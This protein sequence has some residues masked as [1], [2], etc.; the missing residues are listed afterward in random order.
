MIGFCLDNVKRHRKTKKSFFL[1][2]KQKL[3]STKK[4]K[5]ET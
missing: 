5:K 4:E 3:Q 2:K 1:E